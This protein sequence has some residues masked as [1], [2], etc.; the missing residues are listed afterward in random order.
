MKSP[1]S[2]SSPWQTAAITAQPEAPALIAPKTNSST[3][4]AFSP[5]IST[6]FSVNCF[7]RTLRAFAV[8]FTTNV[9]MIPPFFAPSHTSR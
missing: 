8:S 5:N 4:Y 6:P 3:L 7:L 2:T 1:S 9:A